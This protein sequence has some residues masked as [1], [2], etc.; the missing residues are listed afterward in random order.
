MPITHSTPSSSG[1]IDAAQWDEAHVGVLEACWP[2]GA[3][4]IS[5]VATNPATLLGFGTWAALAA[6]RVL[7]GIDAGQTEFDTVRETGGAKTHTLDVAE[8]PAHAHV[9]NSNGATT[10]PLRGWAAADTST[11]TPTATG[12]STAPTGGGGAHNNL[13]P[14]QVV[15]MWERT[16]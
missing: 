14:Y 13:Q 7:V 3:V 4:F 6:G 12:Y 2:V 8:M 16:A 1:L 15:H 11:N 10:G 5:M 9:E